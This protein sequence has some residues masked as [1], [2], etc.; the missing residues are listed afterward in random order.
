MTTPPTAAISYLS[1]SLYYRHS[2]RFDA[3]RT[4]ITFIAG[5]V[6]ALVCGGIYAYIVRYMPIVG[7]ITFIITG[8]TGFALGS[9][10]GKLLQWARVRNTTLGLAITALAGLVLVWF[11]WVVY[12]YDLLQQIEIPP[13]L[14]DCV[15]SPQIMWQILL[16][17]NEHGLWSIKEAKPTGIFLWAIWLVEAALLIGIPLWYV[18]KKLD[19]KAFCEA[20]QKWCII[21]PLIDLK[22]L[23]F[24]RA[25]VSRRLESK[26]FSVIADAKEAPKGSLMYWTVSLQGCPSCDTTQTLCIDETVLTQNKKGQWEKTIKPV[27][28]RLLL[29]P[30][31][32]VA[33]TMAVSQV[34]SAHTEAALAG[35]TKVKDDE[36]AALQALNEST[37]TAAEDSSAA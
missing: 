22:T 16:D 8:G 12:I 29:A 7:W 37:A 18:R 36:A 21:R 35:D 31:D 20:C 19:E 2:G 15:T 25:E 33:M 17:I 9:A 4:L 5:T 26:D 32:T 11:S 14:W 27:V 23:P 24:S 13:T 1:S 34:R 6:V 3:G 28:K 30:E 10:M